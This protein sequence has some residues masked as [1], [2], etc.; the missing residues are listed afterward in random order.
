MRVCISHQTALSYLL[1]VPNL[2]RPGDRPSRASVIPEAVV[3]APEA[4]K[5]LNALES[6]L[7]EGCERLD[8]L[9][10]SAAGRRDTKTVLAHLCTTALPTGSF[11][12]TDA[13]GIEFHVCAPELVFL[14]MAGE[15]EFDHLV[16][17]GFA[18][19]SAFR[20][21]SWEPGG[22]VHRE[23]YDAPLA[24]IDRLRAY[25]E[26]LP[27]GTRNRAVALRA[28][29]Y[30]RPGARSPRE[31]GLAMVIGL[32][33]SLGG[34]AL[35]E[36]SMN[37]EVRVYDG[38]D[39]RGEPRWVTRIPDI[40]VVARDRT[41]RERRVGVDYDAKSTHGGPVRVQRD[42]DRRNLLAPVPTFTHITLGSAQVDDYVAFCR[43]LDRI[44]R[45]LGQRRKPR[46]VGNPD[47]ARNRRLVATTRSRQFDL[48][49]RVLGAECPLL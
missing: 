2:R 39:A 27:E 21:D 43:E 44:R 47:S 31:A 15:V 33:L 26:R 13:M 24:T 35:G 42:V 30:V 22:C 32:P 20:L 23:G 7:P 16:Y 8:V 17:I 49:N 12:P 45:A 25:L 19:C 9:V 14:Q 10:S 28:L 46:L 41:G 1:R 38:I 34:H 48:W 3:A 37:P 6:Y 36:T 18:L 29:R 5:L 4:R 11:I 40:L